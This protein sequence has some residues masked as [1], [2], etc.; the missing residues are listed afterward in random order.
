MK[1]SAM[2]NEPCEY[3][4]PGTDEAATLKQHGIKRVP[5]AAYEIG[6]YRYSTLA[7]AVAQAQRQVYLAN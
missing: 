6:G 1:D 3:C 7:Q 2:T 5:A 4:T